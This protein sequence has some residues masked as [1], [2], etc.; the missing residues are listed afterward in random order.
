MTM[1]ARNRNKWKDKIKRRM[2]TVREWEENMTRKHRDNQQEM[3]NV[4]R[5]VKRDPARDS[6]RFEWENCGRLCKTKT[7]LKAHQRMTHRE[8]TVVFNVASVVNPS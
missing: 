4:K 5:N 8:K 3:D 7:E 2:E 6:L 1:Y